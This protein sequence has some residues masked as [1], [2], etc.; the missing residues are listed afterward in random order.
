MHMYAQLYH[1]CTFISV[2][3]CVVSVFDSYDTWSTINVDLPALLDIDPLM[4]QKER[5]MAALELSV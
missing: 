1:A 3:M 5:P 2:C 4:P